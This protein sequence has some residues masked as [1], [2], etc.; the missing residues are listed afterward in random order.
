MVVLVLISV[1]MAAVAM[2]LIAWPLLRRANQPGVQASELNV[3]VLQNQLQELEQELNCGT[4][5]ET[6]YHALRAD[7]ERVVAESLE[8]ETHRA[9]SGNRLLV[10]ILLVVI[11]AMA[12]TVYS[13]V[14]S[15]EH[16][17]IAGAV[18]P[19]RQAAEMPVGES[20]VM[21]EDVGDMVESLHARLEQ[22]PDDLRGWVLLAR[23][24]LFMQD[25]AGAADAFQRAVDGGIEDAAVITQYADVLSHLRNGV[26]AGRPESLVQQALK[27][28]PHHGQAL[29][30]AGN[31]ALQ[32]GREEAALVYWR[33][34]QPLLEPGSQAAQTLDENIRLVERQLRQ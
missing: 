3:A 30:L 23:S 21:G 13:M 5:N 4:I 20:P 9:S 26:M 7:L 19:E 12:L 25:Y 24:L 29:W 27:L 6:D 28:N 1:L 14:G 31:A 22:D 15:P 34:L 18:S 33:R 16:H 2:A 32:A 8:E 10:A 11:P 17:K